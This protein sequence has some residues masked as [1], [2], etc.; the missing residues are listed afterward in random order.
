[1][2]ADYKSNLNALK[3]ASTCFLPQCLGGEDRLAIQLHIRMK[4]LAVVAGGVN[5]SLKTLESAAAQW[6]H[7]LSEDERQSV[8]LYLDLQNAI[9]AGAQFTSGTGIN[10]LK[11]DA[12]CIACLGIEAKRNLLLYLK[13]KLN[14]LGEPE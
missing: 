11:K 9:G 13:W 5:Y 7:N 4:N 8:A 6:L 1:M 12:K 10:G 2:P 3:V 14:T